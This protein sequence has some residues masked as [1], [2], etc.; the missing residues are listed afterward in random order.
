MLSN[1]LCTNEGLQSLYLIFILLFFASS[2]LITIYLWGLKKNIDLFPPKILSI[3]IMAFTY[4]I[5]DIFIYQVDMHTI[6]AFVLIFIILSFMEYNENDIYIIFKNFFFPISLDNESYYKSIIMV[7][8]SSSISFLCVSF[9]TKYIIS[10][11][12][13]Q[14]LSQIQN[15]ILITK[16]VDLNWLVLVSTLGTMTLIYLHVEKNIKVYI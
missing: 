3:V 13:N 16:F 4:S 11:V 7:I 15:Q 5:F 10:L 2:S 9:L 1:N 6:I 12:E 8:I 14:T